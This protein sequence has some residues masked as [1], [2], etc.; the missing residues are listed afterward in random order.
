M[1]GA[2]VSTTKGTGRTIVRELVLR[3]SPERVFAAW[4]EPAELARWFGTRAEVDLRVGGRWRFVWATGEG[5][6]AHG[7]GVYRVIDPPRRLVYTWEDNG[8]GPTVVTV[9]LTPEDD[10]TRLRVTESGF[11]EGDDWDRHYQD[12][13]DGW[14][15]ELEELRAWIEEGRPQVAL[16]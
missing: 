3:A 4:T 10:G 9:E 16:A 12:N 6:E 8:A 14:T 2:G 1:G 11:G 7:T 13:S 5:T 15:A